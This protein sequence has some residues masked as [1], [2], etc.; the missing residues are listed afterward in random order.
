MSKSTIFRELILKVV[1]PVCLGFCV[2][3][4]FSYIHTKNLLLEAH[5]E[6]N[7]LLTNKI[8]H[9]LEFQ[10]IALDAHEELLENM[11]KEY[12]HALVDNY[13]YSTQ[14]IENA[15]LNKIRLELGMNPVL[16]D[17][18]IINRDGIV[19]NTTFKQDFGLNF[20]DFG[21]DHKNYLIEIFNEGEF[22]SERFTIEAKTN[23]LKKYTYQPTNDGKYIIEI[24]KYSFK[25]D[26]II[27]TF[28]SYINNIAIENQSIANI[29][30]FIGADNP[31][32]FNQGVKV[33]TGHEEL[34]RDI[35]NTQTSKT[36]AYT[37]N[38]K[39]LLAEYYYLDMRNTYLYKGMVVN[40]ISDR[41]IEQRTLENELL[42]NILL[43]SLTIIVITYLIYRKSRNLSTP[44]KKLADHV[45]GISEGNYGSR[46][47]IEGTSEVAELATRFN[48]MIEKIELRD[49][50]NQEQH[51]K[52]EKQ[53]EE[54]IR[55][56]H[57][58]ERLSIVASKTDNAIAIYDI[59]RTLTWI[60]EGFVKL[61]GYTFNEVLHNIGSTLEEINNDPDV[62]N[63]FKICVRTKQSVNFES[64]ATT[65]SAVKIWVHTTLT[66]IL[67]SNNRVTHLISI[68][69]NVTT[70]KQ[71]ENKL[72]EKNKDIT[73]SINYAKKLQDAILPDSENIKNSFD[74]SFVLLKPKSIVSGDFFWHM[75]QDDLIIVAAADCTGHGIPGAFMSIIGN[76]LLNQ[77]I[78]NGKIYDPGSILYQLRKDLYVS[79]KHR[80]H[81]PIQRDGIDIALC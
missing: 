40:I 14:H 53:K 36:I 17:I 31:F 42:K 73:D 44:I 43:F 66:P 80:L 50:L 68:D 60:N 12:S 3:A 4:V 2:L 58:L 79:L 30:L 41:S 9:Y 75:Q 51:N 6:K 65:K 59:D 28:K 20:F 16:D 38:E 32:S 49:K 35:F 24:G 19:V 78:I 23:R 46:I 55:I 7:L 57:E 22:V 29:N 74:E 18:Y 77:I 26:E 81:Q 11:M 34:L 5:S 52:I 10:D 70:I 39:K 21:E 67:D 71:I 37:E 1:I 13:F 47:E 54:L 76:Y 48:E 69:S 61:Y 62:V 33:K 25:A 72:K 64:E 63:Y 56:N 15:D 27:E 8:R 45:S